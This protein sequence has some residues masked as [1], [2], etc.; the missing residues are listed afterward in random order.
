MSATALRHQFDTA[1]GLRPNLLRGPAP[2]HGNCVT[3]RIFGAWMR[4]GTRFRDE[5]LDLLEP[6]RALAW[7]STY[8]SA[9]C[10]PAIAG[11]AAGFILFPSPLGA[12][13]LVAGAAISFLAGTLIIRTSPGWSAI[14]AVVLVVVLLLPFAKLRLVEHRV[15]RALP[16]YQ[17]AVPSVLDADIAHCSRPNP[18]TAPAYRCS[19]HSSVPPPV[20]ALAKDIWVEW[21]AGRPRVFF[22]LRAD[23]Q[24]L[25]YD[26]DG[27]MTERGRFHDLGG[28]WHLSVGYSR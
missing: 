15:Q 13:A 6:P 3:R 2:P 11:G 23:L 27:T 21:A 5:L 12:V 17:R 10:L 24:V 9:A 20:R 18:W 1:W 4:V 22:D 25:L 8:P 28:G 7:L 14:L 16:E 26:P 19:V